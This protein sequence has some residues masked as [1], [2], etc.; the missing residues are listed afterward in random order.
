MLDKED[1]LS[2]LRRI[3]LIAKG[4]YVSAYKL[5]D[6]QNL[7]PSLLVEQHA[8]TRPN[9]TAVLFEDL[10][11]DYA[12]FNRRINQ[13][14]HALHALGAKAGQKVALLMDNRPEYLMSFNGANK[15]GV[16]SALINTHVTGHQL[17][18]A[19]RICEPSW[20]L[21]GSEHLQHLEE[22]ADNLPVPRQNVL[23]WSEGELKTF[24]GG[25]NFN[26]LLEQAGTHNPDSTGSYDVKHPCCYIYTSGT[27]GLPK[28]AAM[29]NGRFL[30][31][32]F[33]F[34]Y[35]VVGLNDSDVVYQ[36]GLPFYHSSGCVLGWGSTLQSGAA[37]AIRRKFSASHH[38]EDC[39]KYGVTVFGYIGEF[40]RYLLAA[41]QNPAEKQHKIR[42][43]LGA[44][45]RPDIW[46]EFVTRFKIPKVY[47]FYGATEGNVGVVN[48]DGKPGMLGRL[49]PGQVVIAVDDET[50]EIVTDSEGRCTKVS[51]GGYGMLLGQINQ[52]N[53]FDGYVDK[54]KNASKVVQNPFGDGKHYFNTGD[55][56]ELHP[57][58]YVS[59]K[60]RLGDTF[61]WK[62]ENVS[63]ND[64][65]E[66]LTGCDGVKE[67][68]VY[69]VQVPHC[70][71]RAGM[72]ALVVDE[73]AFDLDRFAKYV[74]EKL[75]S[76]SRPLFVRFE[77]ELKL[78]ASFKY[79]KTHLKEDGYDPARCGGDVRFL[80]GDHYVPL[81]PELT[82]RIEEGTL[83]F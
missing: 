32:A 20:I 55:L 3:R 79:V 63:T 67:A 73:Q 52:V 65:Q 60:D 54:S 25:R 9:S 41:P 48:V 59:F 76:Y 33:M 50:G 24:E 14:A 31:A 81:T 74:V 36:S 42:A 57:R 70:D 75:P 2:D 11:Y 34:G 47:E 1:I 7:S 46:D 44:G 64:V 5:R 39:V 71:G 21:L 49:M 72:A 45:L 27:T 28:A 78:T 43:I 19:L 15:V 16:V 80:E 12:A 61:R 4:A 23:V 83:R 37:C 68:N 35:A 38:F 18:H 82:T 69:G 40:C 10:R 30:K 8:A 58:S 29:S 26:A 13:V 56:V 6:G 51:P 53:T 77:K 66:V 62:A 22:V 17:E